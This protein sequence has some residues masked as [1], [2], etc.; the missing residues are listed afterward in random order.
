VET[1]PVTE[2]RGSAGADLDLLPTA[3]LVAL[4]NDEDARV[5]AAVGTATAATAAVVDEVV[6]RLGRGGRLVYVGA[7]TSGRLA[8]LDAE[9]C[10]AT[11]A[12]PPRQVVALVAGA[13]AASVFDREAAEDDEAAGRR[14]LED[15]G[16]GADDAVVAVSAGGRTP[17]VVGAAAAAAAAGAFTACVV[18]VP[19]SRLGEICEREVLV[20]VGPEVLAGSTRLKAGTAQKLVLNTISTVAMIRLGKTYAGL[21]VGVVAANEKLRGRVRRIVAE[22]TGASAEE[23][24]LALAAAGGDTKVAIVSLLAGVDAPDARARLDAAGGNVREALRA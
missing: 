15:L 19:H 2:R 9:E 22:A 6:E 3:E 17:Y 10:Q 20:V 24:D 8:E 13:G 14:A 23:V 7:G 21:M 16:V 11:F 1:T 4:M 18:C 5:P 12:T